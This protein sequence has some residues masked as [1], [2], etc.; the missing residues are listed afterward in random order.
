[1]NRVNLAVL[2]VLL[3][4]LLAGCNRT[5]PQSDARLNTVT[6]ELA[7]IHQHNLDLTSEMVKLKD[8]VAVLRARNATLQASGEVKPSI[9]TGRAD[10]L[11]A[12][13][14]S[15]TKR[16][17]DLEKQLAAQPAVTTSKPAEA[18]AAP[19]PVEDKPANDAGAADRQSEA[20]WPLVKSGDKKAMNDLTELANGS[21][22]EFRDKVIQQARDWV[23]DE[24]ESKQARL[25][26]ASVLVSRFQDLRSE[27]MKQ[28]ALAGE[29]VTEID[30]ALAIDPDYYEARHFL[31][32]MKANYPTFAPEF[33]TANVDLDKALGMQAQMPWEES[34]CEIYAAYSMW[35]RKQ[36]KLDDALAKVNAGLEKSSQDAGLLAEKEAVLAAQAAQG[37]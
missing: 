1:M 2:L 9:D 37:D 34:F 13:I 14:L 20:L 32:I 31:A 35:F 29:I 12:E 3:A 5:D 8:E 4:A 23:K 26:L 28:G 10:A 22:K 15:L 25:T 18:E 24:P 17:S 16:V 21:S 30:K 11:Q 27:P 33:K 36:G 19:K 7:E 6:T